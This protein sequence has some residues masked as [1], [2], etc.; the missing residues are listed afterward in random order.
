MIPLEDI[1]NALATA[2]KRPGFTIYPHS[3]GVTPNA[4]VIGFP[5]GN[6]FD[7]SGSGDFQWPIVVVVN[8]SDA[9]NQR[10]L[11]EQCWGDGSVMDTLSGAKLL[12]GAV[13]IGP[14]S[15]DQHGVVELEENRGSFYGATLVF[16]VLVAPSVD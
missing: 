15:F 11:D 12:G 13:V 2:L 6:A 9:S 3:G 14:G 4:I 16:P 5:Q 10:V 1:R 7:M 8:S